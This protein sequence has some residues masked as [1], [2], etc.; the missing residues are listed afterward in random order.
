MGYAF[1]IFGVLLASALVI[2]TAVMYGVA[3]ESRKAPLE[4]LNDYAGIKTGQ[5]HTEV[6]IAST[7]LP[8]FS[9]NDRYTSGQGSNTLSG[10]YTLYLNVSNNGS[11]VLNSTKATVMYNN[12]FT[13]FTVTSSDVWT[14]MINASMQVSNIYIPSLS[15]PDPGPQ[16]RLSVAAENGISAI[17]P[18]TPTNFTID[19][20]GNGVYTFSWNASFDNRGIAYYLIYRFD[21]NTPTT[22]PNYPTQILSV[23]GNQ[24]SLTSSIP[25]PSP[26][27]TRFFFMTAVDFGGNMAIQSRTLRCSGSSGNCN[28]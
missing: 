15:L 17:A 18:T 7:C 20:N 6:T 13:N 12:S 8:D 3:K 26:C 2:A 9:G 19:Y 10:P 16:L 4:A 5:A 14:P 1:I 27:K 25:C 28:Y 24:T 21:V 11:I 22:C 23:S